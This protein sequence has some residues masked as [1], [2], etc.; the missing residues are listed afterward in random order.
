MTCEAVERVRVRTIPV[1][2][3]APLSLMLTWHPREQSGAPSASSPK[4]RVRAHWVQLPD[5]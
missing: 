5:H 2:R 4:E 3:P 1:K